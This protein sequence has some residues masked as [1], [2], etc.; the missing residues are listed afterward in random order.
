MDIIT[1][2][3]TITIETND[4]QWQVLH[5]ATPDQPP[6]PL[7]TA[8]AQSITDH[9]TARAIPAEAVETVIA[10]WIPEQSLWQ[11]GV[12]TDGEFWQLAAYD[13]G[14][15]FEQSAIAAATALSELQSVP[16]QVI[17][18]DEMPKTGFNGNLTQP[19]MHT[20]PLPSADLARQSPPIE[21]GDW[22]LEIGPLGLVLRQTERWRRRVLLQLVYRGIIVLLFIVLGIGTLTVGLAEVS[23]SY[24]PYVA[25]VIAAILAANMVQQGTRLLS[26][27]RIVL[28]TAAK[29][30]RAERQT[31][32]IIDWRLPFED[33]K[34]LLVSQEMA[35]PQG[36]R[37]RSD[38]M[39]IVQPV[40]V[41]VYDGASFHELM[42][43]GEMGGKS[44]TW[45]TVRGREPSEQRY[46]LR[47]DEYDTP[48]HHAALN[49][50]EVLAVPAY[51]DI[52]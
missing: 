33:V 24:L 18:P 27:Q 41:H 4:G 16:L 46:P 30:I 52:R 14:R 26:Y 42:Q 17:S 31:T 9:Q 44:H 2:T 32:N 12:L 5:Y 22:R 20:E 47:L 37:Q 25:F 38:P 10:G 15:Q 28:D 34:Y 49:V 40:W 21:M 39:Y 36:R 8:T 1:V 7:V 45:E 50:A 3:Q 13:A 51:V 29:E 11:V 35:N 6:R 43:A 48:A 19:S 23:P